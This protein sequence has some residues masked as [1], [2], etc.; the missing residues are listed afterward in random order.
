MPVRSCRF[1]VKRSSERR[2][3]GICLRIRGLAGVIR[4]RRSSDLRT[5][6]I[7]RAMVTQGLITAEELAEIHG[8][9]EEM[10][11]VRPSIAGMEH[12]AAVAGDCG[13]RG[14]YTRP[15]CG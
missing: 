13:G 11:R 9:G 12:Q 4:F 7:D 15:A 3:A 14:R 2:E 6:L 8:V 1:R 5:E 10:E